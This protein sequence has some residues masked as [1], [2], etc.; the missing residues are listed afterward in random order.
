M[1]SISGRR[2][3]LAPRRQPGSR[4]LDRQPGGGKMSNSGKGLS[5][6]QGDKERG[7]PGDEKRQGI[8]STRAFGGRRLI[9]LPPSVPLALSPLLLVSLSRFS[10]RPPSWPA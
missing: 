8:D 6:R 10:S 2:G 5:L 3:T 4:K 7:R 1:A 9:S